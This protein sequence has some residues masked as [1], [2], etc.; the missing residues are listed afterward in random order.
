MPA[1]SAAGENGNGGLCWYLPAM[2]SRSKKVERGRLDVNDRFARAWLRLRD[3]GQ[4]QIVGRAEV[5]AQ[6]SFHG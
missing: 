1:N 5:R 3:V 2:I 6:N 4:F